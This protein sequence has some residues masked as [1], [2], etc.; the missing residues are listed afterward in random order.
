MKYYSLLINTQQERKQ[1]FLLMG[2]SRKYPYLPLPGTIIWFLF[3]QPL[4]V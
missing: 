3:P 4:P 2:G 1:M